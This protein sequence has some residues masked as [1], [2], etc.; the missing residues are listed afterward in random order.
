M[1]QFV[2]LRDEATVIG[3]FEIDVDVSSQRTVFVPDHG[4]AMGEG[5]L[6][7]L[8]QRNLRAGRCA[9]EYPTHFVDI[10]AEVSLV[11][12]IDGITLAALDVLRDILSS[13]TR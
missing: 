12:D 4:G 11:A 1:N 10:V 6:R 9:D 3:V 2:C 5:D 8:P 13:D 7:H